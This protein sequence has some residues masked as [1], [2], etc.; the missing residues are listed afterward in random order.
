MLACL[1]CLGLFWSVHECIR[2]LRGIWECFLLNSHQFPWCTNKSTNIFQ[3][4]WRFQKSQISKCPIVTVI[5]SYREALGEVSKLRY[6]SLLYFS[7]KRSYCTTKHLN[8][9]SHLCNPGSEA[10]SVGLPRH[11]CLLCQ[12]CL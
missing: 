4:T 3:K 7:S 1:G 5:L 12:H 9:G 8:F 10:S 11:L 6:K 2:A